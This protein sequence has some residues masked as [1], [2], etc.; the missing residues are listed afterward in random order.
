M[1]QHYDHYMTIKFSCLLAQKCLSIHIC[2][3]SEKLFLDA[4]RGHPSDNQLPSPL[5]CGCSYH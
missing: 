2:K 1:A 3:T 5:S 4:L